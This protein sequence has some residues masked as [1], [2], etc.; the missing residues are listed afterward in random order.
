M[1]LINAKNNLFPI[2][3][4]TRKTILVVAATQKAMIKKIVESQ[5]TK[6]QTLHLKE[7]EKIEIGI[8]KK[9]KNK[10]EYTT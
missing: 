2:S 5:E 3:Q 1:Q 9:E 4:S 6:E 7:I 10:I 8:K